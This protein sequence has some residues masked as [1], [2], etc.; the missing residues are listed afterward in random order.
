MEEVFPR[1][2]ENSEEFKNYFMID[3]LSHNVMIEGNVSVDSTNA[4]L[5][6]PCWDLIDRGGK[7]WRPMLGL[8]IAKFF[9]VNIDDIEKNRL[10][11]KFTA[12]AELTHNASLIIDD[13]MDK[14]EFRRNQPCVH[15]KFG[16]DIS[17]NAGISLY[18]IPVFK[19]LNSITDTQM[20][21][22]LLESYLEEIMSLQL[23]QGWDIEMNGK[24]RTPSA[25]NYL[26]IAMFKTGVCPRYT[27][28]L[29]KTLINNK[30]YDHIFKELVDIADFLSVSFQIKDD[31]LN[32]SPSNLSQAKG[33][34]GEDIFTGKHT[35]IV[36]HT[37]NSDKSD[38]QKDRLKE[39]L[40]M[41]T[42]SENLIKEAI[43]ILEKNGSIK[44]AE[45]IMNQFADTVLEKCER[46]SK[47]KEFDGQAMQDIS[48]LMNYLIKR[49]I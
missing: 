27:V 25:N 26:E 42:K 36:L 33:F 9:N 47:L 12:L 43:A 5:F 4:G 19:I 48:V 11:Y 7:A 49:N 29:I 21:L 1:K 10:L 13:I 23:G 37:L 45:D 32:I 17:I 20:K 31:L 41:G 28:K 18:Y 8:M 34:L 6:T 38:S 24:N 35:L 40:Y 2:I 22:T 16:E 15:L 14:S 30:N 44:Y 3:N 46:L 39:I